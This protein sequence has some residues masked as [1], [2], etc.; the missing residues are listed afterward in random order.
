MSSRLDV[1]IETQIGA[2][3]KP[4]A[5]FRPPR[6]ENNAYFSPRLACESAPEPAAR[7]I[8]ATPCNRSPCGGTQ[9]TAMQTIAFIHD[10]AFIMLTAGVGT[11]V[12]HLLRQPVVLGYISA[13]VQLGP[14]TL[15]TR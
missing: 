2:R 10:L 8:C 4:G 14:H 9:R 3:V 12:F 6:G 15:F 13:R 11:V 7:P 1:Q 5:E